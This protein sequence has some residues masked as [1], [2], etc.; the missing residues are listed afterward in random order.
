MKNVFWNIVQNPLTDAI[1]E[2]V[3][4]IYLETKFQKNM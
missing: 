4:W 3:N 1:S 2:E